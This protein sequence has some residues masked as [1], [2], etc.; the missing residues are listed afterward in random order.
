MCL[1]NNITV[2]TAAGI[3][4]PFTRASHALGAQHMGLQPSLS[5]FLCRVSHAVRA[6][7]PQRT[8]ACLE[9]WTCALQA[10]C[11][12][13]QRQAG[14][15]AGAGRMRRAPGPVPRSS[16]VEESFLF[17]WPPSAPCDNVLANHPASIAVAGSDEWDHRTI[18]G[19]WNSSCIHVW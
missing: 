19:A 10:S 5:S 15:P 8:D 14:R 18:Y 7:L 17:P 11:Q 2:I 4:L 16:T 12:L 13:P 3:G 9:L 1:H 6:L